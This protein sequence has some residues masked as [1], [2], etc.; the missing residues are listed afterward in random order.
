MH[1]L[2]IFGGEY[3][4]ILGFGKV[5]SDTIKIIFSLQDRPFRDTISIDESGNAGTFLIEYK[6]PNGK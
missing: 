4:K 5:S 3:S 2:D 1:W 6:S